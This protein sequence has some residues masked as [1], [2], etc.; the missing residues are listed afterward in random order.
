MPTSGRFKQ[1]G[2]FNLSV[3]AAQIG[4]TDTSIDSIEKQEFVPVE[5]SIIETQR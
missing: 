1:G 4:L 5:E 3:D 2:T